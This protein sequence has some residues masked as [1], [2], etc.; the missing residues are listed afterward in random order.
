[1][2]LCA[3]QGHAEPIRLLARHGADMQATTPDGRTALHLAA[4]AN[5]A[6][7]VTA[8]LDLGGV[9]VDVLDK[10]AMSALQ[11]ACLKGASEA[12]K[13]LLIG[14]GVIEQADIEQATEPGVATRGSAK[15]PLAPTLLHLACVGG[16]LDLVETLI[17]AGADCDA[18]DAEGWHPLHLAVQFNHQT[19]V[20]RLVAAGAEVDACAEQP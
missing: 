8:L 11:L 6:E 15:A 4:L 14:Q 13:V 12:A 2:H 9:S 16:A 5:R 20:E 17:M 19:L 3:D 1:M 7:V 18:S 10:H